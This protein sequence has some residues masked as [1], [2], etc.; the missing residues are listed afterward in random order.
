[1][2]LEKLDRWVKDEFIPAVEDEGRWLEQFALWLR[3][4][5]LFYSGLTMDEELLSCAGAGINIVGEHEN[6]GSLITMLNK[7]FYIN[8][9][10]WDHLQALAFWWTFDVRMEQALCLWKDVAR[11]SGNIDGTLSALMDIAE[12]TKIGF[13]ALVA[14]KDDG[15][16][17][18]HLLLR[19]YEVLA[20]LQTDDRLDGFWRQL[21]TERE[22]PRFPYIAWRANARAWYKRMIADDSLVIRFKPRLLD[23][24]RQ[25]YGAIASHA[26]SGVSYMLKKTCLSD[27]SD[28]LVC[29]VAEK[30]SDALHPLMIKNKILDDWAPLHILASV[31][32]VFPHGFYGSDF[33]GSGRVYRDFLYG[34]LFA[35]GVQR[36]WVAPALQLLEKHMVFEIMDM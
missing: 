22:I 14:M 25:Y 29:I 28:N 30:L 10:Q 17:P 16:F 18:P 8:N 23:G 36:G 33:S 34:A 12:E 5:S 26:I 9:E 20:K 21:L 24:K 13:P 3:D 15:D 2:G 6:V 27:G 4:P 35:L 32:E 1:M 19:L 7:Q 11:M 31:F